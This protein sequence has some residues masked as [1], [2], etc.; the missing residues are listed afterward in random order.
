[1]NEKKQGTQSLEILVADDDLVSKTMAVMLLEK[2]GHRVRAVED[3]EK[4]LEILLQEQGPRMAILDWVMPGMD[5]TD[6]VREL[7]R[8]GKTRLYLILLTNRNQTSDKVEGL[9]AGA[10][11]YLTKPVDPAELRARVQAGARILEMQDLLDE[12]HR[13]LVHAERAQK[14]TALSYMAGGVAHHFNN[15][16]QSVIGSLDLMRLE[17]GNA[18]QLFP[19]FE[20][21]LSRTMRS[22]LEAAEISRKLVIYLGQS[23]A[24]SKKVD[25]HR[26]LRDMESR[27]LLRSPEGP[28]FLLLLP[29]E[30]VSLTVNE[31]ELDQLLE[32]VITN[33]LEAA[34]KSPLQVELLTTRPAPLPD[35]Q[36]RQPEDWS[37]GD[38]P[39]VLLQ[40]TDQGVGI[41]GKNLSQLFDPFFTTK[42]TGR[43]LGL[44]VCLGLVKR[45]QGAI[46]VHSLPEKGT[47]VRI[48]LPLEPQ[49]DA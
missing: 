46:E 1:M 25:L 36:V 42:F 5:G 45:Y 18:G 16:L 34:P 23:Y 27:W 28:G 8:R 11:D 49:P 47:T 12:K 48:W 13:Q 38:S 35:P 19:H 31:D 41:P 24:R 29:E 33:G 7:R 21:N 9:D 2:F 37:P 39:W 3:G 22:A 15:K 43:G 10:D 44:P 26:F 32:P 6:V 30:P 14:L 20:E 4:A 17:M 40:I